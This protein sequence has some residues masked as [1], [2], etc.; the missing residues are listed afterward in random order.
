MLT[1]RTYVS[2][3]AVFKHSHS[4]KAEPP[5]TLTAEAVQAAIA[6]TDRVKFVDDKA[7]EDVLRGLRGVAC[8]LMLRLTLSKC[9]TLSEIE[10]FTEC[11]ACVPLRNRC[12]WFGSVCRS[13]ELH[14]DQFFIFLFFTFPGTEGGGAGRCLIRYDWCR[15]AGV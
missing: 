4:A 3:A 8:G 6:A 2:H 11:A 12:V 1:L 5:A 10:N 15:L 9:P 13:S 14:R 7:R